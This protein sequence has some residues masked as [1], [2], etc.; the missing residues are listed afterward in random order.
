MK[1]S[2]ITIVLNGMP[3]L[4]YC[5]ESMLPF[6]H[7]I[8]II[9]GGVP[10]CM[11]AANEDGSSKDG[12]VEFLQ[13]FSSDKS[14]VKIIQGKWKSKCEMQNAALK[15]A[16]GDYVWLVDSDEFYRKPD[17]ERMIQ[18][19]QK[20]STITQVN[21]ILYHFWKGFDYIFDCPELFTSP[22][23][24]RRIFKNYPGASFSTHRPP[25]MIWPGYD[26]SVGNMNT[27]GG[28]AVRELGIDL[29]H[30]SYV[31][32]EQVKQKQEFY[33]RMTSQIIL[34]VDR[35]IWYKECFEKWTPENREEIEKKYSIWMGNHH[36]KTKPFTGTHPNVMSDFIKGY[37]YGTNAKSY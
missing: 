25:T 32:F 27:L 17:I 33:G 23:E 37:K 8:I 16:T 1:I 29:L 22:Y 12:T 9:E 18:I 11:F 7:E 24:C 13:K 15:H 28:L 14:N 10:N 20:D 5:L 21:F 36:T 26:K 3:F 31:L 30:Y 4:Q 35:R 34:G 2:Y 19:L 6:A